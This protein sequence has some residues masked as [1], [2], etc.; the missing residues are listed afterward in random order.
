MSFL[1]LDQTVDGPLPVAQGSYSRD[2]ILTSASDHNTPGIAPFMDIGIYGIYYT[3]RG[4][5]S[6]HCI[7]LV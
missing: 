5:Y 7:T 2:L 1:D 3:P 4:E 6:A